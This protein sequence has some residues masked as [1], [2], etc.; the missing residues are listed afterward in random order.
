MRPT[1]KNKP[2]LVMDMYEHAEQMDFGTATA[3]YIDAFFANINWDS[4]MARVE[5]IA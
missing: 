3:K 5:A 1:V 2:L 4:V